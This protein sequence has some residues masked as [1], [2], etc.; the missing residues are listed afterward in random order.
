MISKEEIHE[1][2]DRLES[3]I[4]DDLE[5]QT[6][7]FKQWIKR[8]LDDN[9]KLML[10]MAVCM[11]NGGGGSVV[12]GVAD[13]VKGRSN[14][15]LGVPQEI[16]TTVLQK[17]IYEKTDPHLT[18][19]F[20]DITVSEGTERL[21]LMNVYP[22]MPP[23]TTT[24]G[25]AT[26]RQGKDCIPYTGTLRRKMMDTSIQMDYTAEVIHEDWE[27]LFSHSAMERVREIMSKE[28][29]DE[30]LLTLTD[31]DL[32]RS[33]GALKDNFL[34]KG[35]LLLVGKPEAISR[36]IPQH[37]WSYRKMISDTDY[38]H[39]DDGTHAIPVALYELE[40]YIAVDNP[41]V[42]V[43]SGL[44]HPEFSTYP[45]IALRESLLNA[46]GHRDY[47]MNG[48]IMLKQYKDK[49]ILTNP[50]EFV[51][52]ITPQNILHHPPVARNNHLMDL[53]DRLKLVNRSNLGVSRIFRSLL[54]EGKEPP[55]YREVGN[56]I[57]LTFISSPLNKDFKNLID[58]MTLE[59]NHVDVDHLLILQ[60]LIRHEEIDTS[61]A[62]D[63]A[64]RS[65]E[66][67]RELLSKMQNEFNLLES[68][69]RGKG[70]Y[71]TLSRSAYELLKGDMQ[72]ERRQSLD[73][74]AV[75]IRILSILK[76]DRSLTNKE[77]R[78]LT[79]MNQKQVQ[80]LVKE[81][82]PDGVKIV[83]KGA[84]TKYIYAP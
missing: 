66:Q 34:T 37:R 32:L 5:S 42:T 70:R 62:A 58:H 49:L 56:N 27:D 76:T 64:Q 80:R 69:G 83:G 63:V 21:L 81:L 8:S 39:R 25:A 2:L 35:S 47:R 30:S 13:K 67:A 59:S 57:E 18:P 16:D 75:K 15:I 9:V 61:I 14:A 7:D 41:M 23:Y 38:S 28:R 60:Y 82:E 55:I 72:Y 51:G 71:F 17:R 78:Q 1:L 79:G 10:K 74:E 44:V 43:E 26:I 4:A 11:A 24:D 52:G 50:G 36:F 54:V 29:A 68:V 31:E 20:E 77:I 45:T 48:T 12:F 65:M 84:G 33:I 46:F 40:R 6:L 22:G 3:N 73:K 19:V 53:L